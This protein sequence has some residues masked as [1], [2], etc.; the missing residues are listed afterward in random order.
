MVPVQL[1]REDVLDHAIWT[2]AFLSSCGGRSS[3][4]LLI[5]I[6]IN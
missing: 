1:V 6:G 5:G 2:V 4:P 3:S